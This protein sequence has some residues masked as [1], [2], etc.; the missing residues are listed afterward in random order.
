M[1]M[2]LSSLYFRIALILKEITKVN[3]KTY[4]WR[5][6]KNLIAFVALNSEKLKQIL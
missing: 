5:Y 6:P 4:C 3:I 1:E 2:Q